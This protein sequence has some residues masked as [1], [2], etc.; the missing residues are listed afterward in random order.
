MKFRPLKDNVVV[1]VLE[2]G[3]KTKGASAKMDRR[4]LPQ[5]PQWT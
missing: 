3:E 4:S 2:A 5:P 1:E